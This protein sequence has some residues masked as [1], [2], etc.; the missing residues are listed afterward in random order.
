VELARGGAKVIEEAVRLP[1]GI[2]SV[3]AHLSLHQE[4]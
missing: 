2:V 3:G 4:E 1:E